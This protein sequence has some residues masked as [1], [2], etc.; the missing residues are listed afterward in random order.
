M[1]LSEKD[2]VIFLSLVNENKQI[3]K[4]LVEKCH[5][6]TSYQAVNIDYRR[7]I[8]VIEKN[9]ELSGVLVST[10]EVKLFYNYQFLL[11]VYIW[12]LEVSENKM[13]S[14]N[15]FLSTQLSSQ[16]DIIA[17]H[18]IVQECKYQQFLYS[19]Y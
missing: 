8:L 16:K 14:L 7:I 10:I 11:Q 6:S 9:L 19:G 12:L 13:K 18:Q 3:F 4:V 17:Y 2:K 1:K 5:L 15:F